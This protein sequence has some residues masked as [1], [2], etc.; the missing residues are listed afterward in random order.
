MPERKKRY[1]KPSELSKTKA[2][3]KLSPSAALYNLSLE[4]AGGAGPEP[5][6]FSPAFYG[7][8]PENEMFRR[9]LM[10]LLG[11]TASDLTDGRLPQTADQAIQW[12][13]DKYP[14]RRNKEVTG[15]RI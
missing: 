14:D 12:R 8:D 10:S 3:Q 7:A 11:V 1:E 15:G 5:T 6:P 4:P 9:L 13:M 2:G